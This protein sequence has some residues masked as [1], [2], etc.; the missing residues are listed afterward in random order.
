LE[1]PPVLTPRSMDVA[2]VLVAQGAGVVDA[3]G[4]RRCAGAGRAGVAQ[5]PGSASSPV[6]VPGVSPVGRSVVLAALVPVLVLVLVSVVPGSSPQAA[7][8]RWT[9]SSGAR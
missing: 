2:A 9:V 7:S 1:R 8:E 6:V 3:R 5:G 4:G